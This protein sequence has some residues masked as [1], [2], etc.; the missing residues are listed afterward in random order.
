MCSSDLAAGSLSVNVNQA[1]DAADK[2]VDYSEGKTELRVATGPASSLR[3]DMDGA[4]GELIQARG[5]LDLDVFGFLQASGDFALEKSTGQIRLADL[6]S[7]PDVDESAEPIEVEILTLG[8]SNVSAFAGLN[9]GTGDALGL[10]LSGVELGVALYTDKADATRSWTSVQASA[11]GV[12]FVGVEG[13]T[14]SADTLS[15]SINQAGK[16]GDAV[17][18]YGDGKTELSVATGPSSDLTLS[19]DGS[20]GELLQVSGNLELDVFGFLQVSGSFAIEKSS[21][22][23]TLADPDGEG[24]EQGEE[25]EVDQ[26]T[27]GASGVRGFAGLNGGTDGA[28]GLELSGVEFGLALMSSKADAQR[29]WTSLQGSVESAAFVGVDG[30]TVSGDTLSLSINRASQADDLVVDYGQGKTELE[31]ATGPESDLTLSLDGSQGQTLSVSG[32]LEVDVFGFFQ[33]QG[34]FAVEKRTD[35]VM[36]SDGEFD[37]DRQVITE[38]TRLEVDLLTIGGAGIDAFAGMNGGTAEAIGLNLSDVN[39]GL[40][41][42]SER[43]G[44]QRQFTSLKATAGSIGFVGIE[45]G[46]AHV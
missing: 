24:S 46:R 31:I 36:L 29:K 41:L 16:A 11:S 10:Q 27:V 26:L 13:L 37:D 32:N 44:D 8:G 34:S 3:L 1:G 17:V 14:L 28:L 12:A 45:I 21:N 23:V 5:H 15:V 30:L 25:V 6:A 4:K 33:A 35:T 22:T 18:D 39:F 20:K 40:A 19:M 9:G 43:G 38:P 7:T 2:V 42:A